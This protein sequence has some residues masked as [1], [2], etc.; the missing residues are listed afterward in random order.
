MMDV[1]PLPV[2]PTIASVSPALM[3]KEISFKT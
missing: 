2:W 3:V 1:L